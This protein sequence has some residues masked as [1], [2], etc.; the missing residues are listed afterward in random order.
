[1]T[2][3]GTPT[4]QRLRTAGILLIVAL[5]TEAISLF[6]A[7]PLSFVALVGIGGVLLFVGLI[8]YLLSLVSAKHASE[9]DS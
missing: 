4:E 9:S 5:V 1:M 2:N 6:W 7:R 3:N 8:V